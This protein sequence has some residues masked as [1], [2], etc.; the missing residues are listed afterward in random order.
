MADHAS[1]RRHGR[2]AG[3]VALGGAA[4]T[5]A[6]ATITA[7]LPAAGGFPLAVALINIVGAFALGWLLGA[8]AAR[9][10]ETP[11]RTRARLFLGTGV[12]GGFTTYGTFIDDEDMLIGMTEMAGTWILFGLPT[13][14]LGIAAA[15]AGSL[16]GRRSSPAMRRIHR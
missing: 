11:A 2:D 7:L 8:T 12:L 13:I 10:A 14:L 6:R 3:L 1:N 15:W 4:G 9:G 16:L 5:L